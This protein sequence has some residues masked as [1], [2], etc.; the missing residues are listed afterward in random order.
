[1]PGFFGMIDDNNCRN[2]IYND[3]PG[4]TYTPVT[5]DEKAGLGYYI[6]RYVIP[7]FLNDKIFY[8]DADLL[9][10]TDGILLN[11]P[12]L[13]RKYK[14]ATNFEL[15]KEIFVRNGITGI[16]EIKGNFSGVIFNKN[17]KTWHIFTD[18]VSSKPV[19][20]FFDENKKSLLFGSE[21][22]VIIA[23]LRKLGHTPRL[24][25]TGAYCLLTF[26]FMIGDNTL[27]QKIKKIPPGSILTCYDGKITIDQY[28][29][30]SSTPEIP[31]SE[32][33]IIKKI[34]ELY[35][36]A[37]R[38]EY[39]K[40]LEYNYS[41]IAT[42]SGG[43]DSRMNVMNAKRVGYTD[44]L[45][46]CFSQG[47]YL[48]EVIAK[49]IASDNYFDFIFRALDSGNY[50]KNI[51]EMVLV[52][53]GL[54]L[55]SGAVSIL[56]SLKLLNWTKYGLLHTGQ[57]YFG[58]ADDSDR[59]LPMDND[60]V[61][62]TAYSVKL[63][64]DHLIQRLNI[65]QKYDNFELFGLYEPGFNGQFN[66]YRVIEQYSEFSSPLHDRDFLE[67]AFRI[68]ASIKN[69][70]LYE[71]WL[72]SKVPEAAEYVW[73]KTGVKPGAGFWRKLPY[74]IFRFL[75]A[76]YLGRSNINSMNPFEYWY[77]TTPG[78][79]EFFETYFVT[80]ISL[81]NQHPDLKSDAERLF[82]EGTC[83][84]K[85]QVLTLLAAMKLHQFCD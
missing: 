14:V 76:K 16:S 64:D 66:G 30:F 75:R 10:C 40:D 49:K 8:E 56:S 53:D 79:K 37:I 80:N 15:L 13:R 24:S 67:Y 23:G 58:S 27:E 43:L 50:L 62:T 73:E 69:N 20:Y 18:H 61:R 42:L 77:K 7:K 26:G 63:L 35:Q 47:G 4:L 65:L 38:L 33:E 45:C 72:L 48:D 60:S 36:E 28:Y 31:D 9:I 83:Q 85:T 29:K 57:L 25:E 84:E 22:K 74:S 12:Q 19:F 21:L 3:I 54:T 68:P 2:P 1:M 46:L 32:D 78:L 34:D 81:L 44:I 71:K 39:D 55:Y 51:D 41:H 59:S 17:T 82:K 11:S 52:N 5:Y 6:K 70:Y